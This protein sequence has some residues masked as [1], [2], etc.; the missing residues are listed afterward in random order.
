MM[1]HAANEKE[2]NERKAYPLFTSLSFSF[3]YF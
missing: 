3:N 1:L 2:L